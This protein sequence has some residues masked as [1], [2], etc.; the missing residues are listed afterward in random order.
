MF[1]KDR[2]TTELIHNRYKKFKFMT[3]EYVFR[4]KL[5]YC[6]SMKK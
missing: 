5:Y 1:Q 6:M 2:I 4:K 3:R